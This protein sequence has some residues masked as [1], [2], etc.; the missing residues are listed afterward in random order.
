MRIKAY[1][2]N[3]KGK[4]KE[5][6]YLPCDIIV[7]RNEIVEFIGSFD[8]GIFPREFNSELSIIEKIYKTH[9]TKQRVP[10]G[11][12]Y[13]IQYSTDKGLMNIYLDINKIEYLRLKWGMKKFLIQS[14]EF[15]IGLSIGLIL[16][17]L[18][19]ILKKCP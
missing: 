3:G 4:Y 13:Y 17:I 16:F 14:K 2:Y 18:G 5:N 9:N 1:T 11:C 7:K 12:K 10:N 19:L 8:V 15:I 6:E